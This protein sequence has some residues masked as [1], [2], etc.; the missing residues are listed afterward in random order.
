MTGTDGRNLWGLQQISG[1]KS[2]LP[3]DLNL[4]LGT[5]MFSSHEVEGWPMCTS[6]YLHCH[7]CVASV[8]S[9]SIFTEETEGRFSQK[10]LLAYI[11]VKGNQLQWKLDDVN[12]WKHKI[13]CV[14]QVF[15]YS[16]KF[17]DKFQN[18]LCVTCVQILQ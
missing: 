18:N 4:G 7:S 3:C 16:S 8:E 11:Q 10:G 17:S 14:L 5:Y 13:I 6:L 9:V 1:I 12:N 2:L 15:K